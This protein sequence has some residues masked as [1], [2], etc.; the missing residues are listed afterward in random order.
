[1]GAHS[2]GGASPLA[3]GY[4]GHFTGAKS[5]NHFDERYFSQMVDPSLNWKNE[6]RG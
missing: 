5:R 1:M 4:L 6:V 3:S 2:L